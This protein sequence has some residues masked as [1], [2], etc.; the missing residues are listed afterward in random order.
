MNRFF[1]TLAL[2]ITSVGAFAQQALGTKS[3]LIA[4]QT[5]APPSGPSIW[6]FGP[7][8]I[9]LGIILMLLKF[10]L[11]KALAKFNRKLSTP[12]NSPIVLEESAAFATGTLQVVTV[13]G[14]SLLL[15]ITPQ[16]V[17]CL[18]KLDPAPQQADE[19]AFFEL[20]DEQATSPRPQK[21]VTPSDTTEPKKSKVHPGAKSYAKA[22]A[23]TAKTSDSQTPTDETDNREDVLGR[24]QELQKLANS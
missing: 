2:G 18:A 14:N 21:I 12:L 3:D 4:P 24:L 9:A 11:P 1:T 23:K 19:P 8:I 5:H 22:S 15:A 16:G 6:Q 17:S 20:L 10:A 7:M 13:R